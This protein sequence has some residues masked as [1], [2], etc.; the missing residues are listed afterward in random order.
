MFLVK[1][2]GTFQASR[3][4]REVANP[5]SSDLAGSQNRN[6]RFQSN[7]SFAGRELRGTLP[8]P[9]IEINSEANAARLIGS[10]P[11][12]SRFPPSTASLAPAHKKSFNNI[13]DVFRSRC[14]CHHQTTRSLT[15][16]RLANKPGDDP[17][18]IVLEQL[19]WSI[20][21]GQTKANRAGPV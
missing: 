6:C 9:V 18:A 8:F 11:L 20:S 19:S 5:A 10:L 1:L 12:G 21:I 16:D 2:N 14:C 15:I 4:E 7:L 3:M 13:S 17:S